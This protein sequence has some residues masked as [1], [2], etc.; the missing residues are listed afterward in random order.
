VP[1][2]IIIAC[3]ILSGCATQIHLVSQGF[4]DDQL[5]E[6]KDELS[7]VGFNVS[8]SSISIPTHYANTVIALNPAH[9]P[10]DDID[11][12][13]RLLGQLTLEPAQISR[14]GADKHFYYHGHIG[15]YLRHPEIKLSHQMPPYVES[16]NCLS[17]YATLGFNTNQRMHLE[18]G[19]NIN[20]ELMLT[21]KQGQWAFDSSELIVTPLQQ[22]PA[23]FIKH[24][25]I[26][27]THVGPRPALLYSPQQKN[28]P[29]AALNCSFEVI[30]ID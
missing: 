9:S 3:L 26:R 29:I 12:L 2:F 5:T 4:S 28:H 24:N 20:G 21:T 14:F 11:T 15:L 8:L 30:F 25:I 1:K 23:S 19:N 7:H 10:Q 27:N 16:V 22:P 17:G 6:I 13:Q 18:T